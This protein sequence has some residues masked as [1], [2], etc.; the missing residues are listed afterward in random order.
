MVDEL[1]QYHGTKVS[2]GKFPKLSE[3]NKDKP[4]L[5]PQDEYVFK[6]IAR[7][8]NEKAKGFKKSDAQE[9]PIVTK[10]FLT[11]EEQETK[12]L[13]V[14]SHRIDTI[15]FGNSDGSM[16]SG[17]VQFLEDIGQPIKK[18]GPGE[19]IHWGTKFLIGMRIRARAELRKK[20]GVFVIDEYQMKKG[21]PRAYKE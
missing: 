2:E 21:S 8:V 16:K 10:V 18:P 1:D 14:T 5:N 9:A 12:N 19:Q 17:V 20:D 13:I 6:L 11:W 15:S 4:K 3:L 7:E